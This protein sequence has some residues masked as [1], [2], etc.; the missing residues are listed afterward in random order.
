MSDIGLPPPPPPPPPE[1]GGEAY[2][3]NP[4]GALVQ[5]PPLVLRCKV[6]L[7]GD[8][9]AGK[10]S[11]AKVFQGGAQSFPKNY[12]MTIGVDFLVKRV[13]IPE[14]NVA[15]ELYI[16]DCGGFSVCQDSL[17]PQ[18]ETANAMML[19]YDVANP[20]SLSHLEDWYAQLKYAR[21]ESAISG[22]V[23]ATKTDLMDQPG[24]IPVEQGHQFCAE[25][26]LEMHWK[27]RR[28]DERRSSAPRL[29]E[30]CS[31][32]GVVDAPF[33]FIAERFYHKYGERK[34]ELENLH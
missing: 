24:C 5:P 33:H 31:S 23:I 7:L 13:N 4:F 15:V 16:V 18:W 22:V 29:F 28:E 27:S 32:R 25:R 17:R 26:G 8:S 21:G 34:Q 11:L 14:T 1:E 9:A 10:T 20:E 3:S 30:T 6:V 2:G 19:V 12:N